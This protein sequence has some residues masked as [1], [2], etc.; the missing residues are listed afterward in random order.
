MFRLVK[1]LYQLSW[2][3]EASDF[4]ES[5]KSSFPDQAQVEACLHLEKD[6]KQALVDGGGDASQSR[7]IMNT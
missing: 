1:C 6:I 7:E 4:I 2:L 3:R 5:F